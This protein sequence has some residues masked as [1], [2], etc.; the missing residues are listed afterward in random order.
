[1]QEYSRTNV[2]VPVWRL[3]PDPCQEA[4]A[5]TAVCMQCPC[6]VYMKTLP[7]QMSVLANIGNVH[8]H[9]YWSVN[10]LTEE[11]GSPGYMPPVQGHILQ[12][13]SLELDPLSH[14]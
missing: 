2:I 7:L 8:V 13:A 6:R 4:E 10:M 1:M 9:D 14:Y 11:T 5:T 3:E 12:N